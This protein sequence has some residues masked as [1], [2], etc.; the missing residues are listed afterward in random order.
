MERAKL[1]LLHI[2]D[3][4]G[5]AIDSA[6]AAPPLSPS[7]L[8]SIA[9]ALGRPMPG[10]LVEFYRTGAGAVSHRYSFE[11]DPDDENQTA[12][13]QGLFPHQTSVYGGAQIGSAWDITEYVADCS[14]WARMFREEGW[15]EQADLWSSSLPF[16]RIDNG[17]YIALS[18]D[19]GNDPPILYLSHDDESQR[20]AESFSGFLSTWE[21]LAYIGPESWMLEPFQ[22]PDGL[23]TAD[24][25]RAKQLRG[26]LAVEPG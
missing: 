6:A 26:Y 7:E 19:G 18:T 17:D 22:S 2:S 1:Y 12:L 24:S 10:A 15:E 9:A 14:E 20:I 25:V 4:P 5:I 23:L 8:Q 11:Y 3:R 21:R 16:K 13:H